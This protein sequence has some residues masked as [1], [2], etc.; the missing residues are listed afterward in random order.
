MKWLQFGVIQM[1]GGY[2]KPN[3]SYVKWG[4]PL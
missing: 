3:S 1:G 4:L 2:G